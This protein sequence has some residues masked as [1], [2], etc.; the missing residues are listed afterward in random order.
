VGDVDARVCVP[1]DRCETVVEPGPDAD[2]G[3]ASSGADA[4]DDVSTG[5]DAGDAGSEG[6]DTGT[7]GEG[8]GGGCGGGGHGHA[9]LML[10]LGAFLAWQRRA[11]HRIS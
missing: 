9:A 4:D 10:G 8:S 11:S 6:P 2:G 5:A 7:V 1:A 3:D